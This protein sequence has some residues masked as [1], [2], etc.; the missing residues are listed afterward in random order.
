[1]RLD[2]FLDDNRDVPGAGLSL[3]AAGS[4]LL[5]AFVPLLLSGCFCGGRFG[6][7]QQP[8][9]KGELVLQRV[10]AF[11]TAAVNTCLKD[12][13]NL[14]LALDFLVRGFEQKK[15]LGVLFE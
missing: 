7:S 11:G 4:F 9:G 8:I 1:L 14:A 5:F 2:D 15:H 12:L 3:G 10:E 13:D 6:L